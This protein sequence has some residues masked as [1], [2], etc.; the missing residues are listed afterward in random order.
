MLLLRRINGN[1][2]CYVEKIESNQPRT[3][4]EPTK[5]TARCGVCLE[6]CGEKNTAT[7]ECGHKTHLNCFI[8]ALSTSDNCIYCRKTL[9]LRKDTLNGEF[10]TNFDLGNTILTASVTIIV[11]GILVYLILKN[12]S[13]FIVPGNSE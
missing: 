7:T 5:M 1:V 10:Q 12:Y 4:T 13:L 6:E 8:Q 3:T 11:Y 9:N 2:C